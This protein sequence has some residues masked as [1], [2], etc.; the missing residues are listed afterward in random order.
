[1]G[2]YQFLLLRF[3]R[4]L[5]LNGEPK[6]EG[7]S[8][9][10]WLHWR[11][12]QG[13]GSPKAVFSCLKTKNL[14]KPSKTIDLD[15]PV[16]LFIGVLCNLQQ[17][18]P[19]RWLGKTPSPK[20]QVGWTILRID[21]RPVPGSFD[22]ALMTLQ[23]SPGG[24]SVQVGGVWKESIFA[25]KTEVLGCQGSGF[26]M[27]FGL[28]FWFLGKFLKGFLEGFQVGRLLVDTNNGKIYALKKDVHTHF[29]QHERHARQQSAY[30][31][32]S[33]CTSWIFVWKTLSPQCGSQPCRK[34]T[35]LVASWPAF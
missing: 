23:M 10:A 13:S 21:G 33:R 4:R 8:R 29:L 15:L 28:D 27:V 22:K 20:V 6:D 34:S 1:M 3:F 18:A 24:A 26:G 2:L 32:K 25:F 35:K 14:Q 30:D 7:E 9:E 12:Q 5:P 31:P 16:G 11:Q 17:T 19:F